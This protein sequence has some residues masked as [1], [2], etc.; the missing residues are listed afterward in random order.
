M[1]RK[2]VATALAVWLIWAAFGGWS[3]N[4]LPDKV[5]A[6][7]VLG[8]GGSVSSSMD[9]VNG[10]PAN[11]GD[12]VYYSTTNASYALLVG[13]DSYTPA[14]DVV[15]ARVVR[16]VGASGAWDWDNVNF[17]ANVVVIVETIRGVNLWANVNYTT[18]LDATMDASG[19]QDLGDGELEALPPLTLTPAGS[20]VAVSWTRLTDANGNV[21]SY[22]VYHNTAPAPP[23]T[24]IARVT[25]GPTPSYNHA[26]LA[27]GRHCYTLGVN[28]RRD[29]AGGVYTTTGRSE[30]VCATVT[31]PAPWIVSTDPADG[32]LNVPLNQNIVVEF[33]E[34]IV[35]G[36]LQYTIA[37]TITL[38][39]TGT[40]PVTFTH[41]DFTACQTYTMRITQA[42]DVDGLDLIPSPP[43]VTPN[44]WT[45]TS[46]CQFPYVVTTVPASGA[47]QVP[48]GNSVVVTYSENMV[49]ANVDF[50]P[51]PGSKSCNAA[52]LTV[53]TCTA[54]FVPG[55]TYTAWA[56]GTDS[57]GNAVIVQTAPNPFTFTINVPPAVTLTAP[58]TGECH[59]GGSQLLIAWTMSDTETAVGSLRVSLYY[60]STA[61]NPIFED[62]P[63]FQNFGWTI[64]TTLNGNVFLTLEVTDEAGESDSA[65]SANVEIDSTA[66]S[67]VLPVSP[68]SGQ[69][70][71]ATNLNIRITFSEPMDRAATELAFQ[72]SPNITPRAYGWGPGNVLTIY[73]NS[74]AF[75]AATVYTISFG[76]G[77]VDDCD[78][79]MALDP[80]FT[81]TFTTGAG[82][83]RPRP[84]TNLAAG[85]ATA[86][87]IPLS[88]TAPTLYTDNSAIGNPTA[89]RYIVE[90]SASQTGP[91]TVLTATSIPETD[92]Q[93]QSV[94]AGQ[95]YYYRVTAVDPDYGPSEPTAPIQATAGVAPGPGFDWL[96]ILIPIVVILVVV[97]LFLLLRKKKPVAVPPAKAP[98]G[99]PQA[100]AEA[101]EPAPPEEAVA[102]PTDEAAGGEKFIPCPNCGT[103]VKPTDAECFVCGAKL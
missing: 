88:W 21:V 27:S 85:D 12:A 37:P 53:Q 4:A 102:E 100:P 56:N 75:A 73:H 40:D 96:V 59:S 52:P 16:N 32:A 43:P 77:A 2:Y 15:E 36:S 1:A 34:P 51:Q 62:Q 25:Q 98:A 60:T 80:A 69:T 38:T 72:I 93:D 67:V 86:T 66:P 7:G 44:P 74:T 41:P 90:R 24:S 20:D 64:P 103:M 13:A 99:A 79:G 71:V 92:Y 18:S 22:E 10:N 39:P 54:L 50:S 35:L 49:T 30:P 42:R 97:G 45:F 8:P 91:W 101:G 89:L 65:I 14:D 5:V 94:V 29:P 9:P 58:G 57:D 33:S 55:V 31:G 95:A 70:G 46:L 76:P 48:A 26:G 47:Q 6:G 11:F 83:K 19:I 3:A 61:T 68:P 87:A 28:Y 23:W 78:P 17:A 82:A 84:P 81:S 63:G